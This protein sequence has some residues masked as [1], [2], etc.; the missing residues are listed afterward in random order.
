M[1]SSSYCIAK[2]WDGHFFSFF[3]HYYTW[4]KFWTH[5]VFWVRI[6]EEI[7]VKEKVKYIYTRN[8]LIFVETH[9]LLDKGFWMKKLCPK[10]VQ[11][12]FF[13][14]H[15][16]VTVPLLRAHVVIYT[17]FLQFHIWKAPQKNLLYSKSLIWPRLFEVWT[18]FF[19]SKHFVLPSPSF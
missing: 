4:I 7:L 18:S 13:T 14:P 11:S 16:L 2:A 6:K 15:S 17:C 9:W 10:K 8:L 3:T 1:N 19:P 12:L 5:L